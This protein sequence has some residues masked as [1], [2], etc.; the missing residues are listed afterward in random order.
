MMTAPVASSPERWLGSFNDTMSAFALSSVLASVAIA[1]VGAWLGGQQ[2]R[3]GVDEWAYVSGRSAADLHHSSLR[4]TLLISTG[5]Y[6]LVLTSMT[7][8]TLWRGGAPPPEDLHLVLV[9]VA[10]VASGIAHAGMGVLLGRTFPRYVALPVAAATPYAAYFVSVSYEGIPGIQ[11]LT[12][13]ETRTWTYVMPNVAT[14]AIEAAFW[15]GVASM[16]VLACMGRWAWSIRCGL[17][18]SA[19][20][21]VGILAGET[22][23]DVPD[24][25]SPACRPGEIT[26]CTDQAHRS[27]LPS[28]VEQVMSAA[29]ALPTTLRPRRVVSDDTL[30]ASASDLVAPPIR[31]NESPAF[32]IDQDMFRISFGDEVLGRCL[33]HGADTS[34]DA[35]DVTS[36]LLIWWRVRAGV[37]PAI[38]A[39]LG[40]PSFGPSGAP[41]SMRAKA[42]SFARLAPGVQASWLEKWAPDIRDCNLEDVDPP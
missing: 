40:A 11:L 12:A 4:A 26:V 39:Y 42:E 15:A 30:R 34:S 22:Y 6:L 2:R 24:A 3:W 5:C 27:V 37:D 20:L 23:V 19:V 28:Y 25:S 13:G 8:L 7:V 18:V 35:Q 14:V 41:A 1:S 17:G 33:H 16:V 38:P 10:I 36:F 21:A 29:S 31:G 9:P 32:V